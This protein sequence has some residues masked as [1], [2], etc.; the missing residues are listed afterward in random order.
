MWLLQPD[1]RQREREFR[2]RN[3][4]YYKQNKSKK[5]EK[6]SLRCKPLLGVRQMVFHGE[7]PSL[8]FCFFFT[9]GQKLHEIMLFIYLLSLQLKTPLN[10]IWQ[11]SNSVYSSPTI[12]STGG[13]N[14]FFI[15][16]VQNFYKGCWQF[17]SA[18]APKTLQRQTHWAGVAGARP[19]PLSPPGRWCCGDCNDIICVLGGKSCPTHLQ[20]GGGEGETKVSVWDV[21]QRLCPSSAQPHYSPWCKTKPVWAHSTWRW[22]LH[23]C[24]QWHQIPTTGSQTGGGWKG[25]LG[26]IWSKSGYLNQWK[27]YFVLFH[28]LQTV[29]GMLRPPHLAVFIRFLGYKIY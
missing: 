5:K 19:A 11:C 28:S 17:H 26:V 12:S 22:W 18:S 23:P 10:Q 25:L 27:Y 15:F 13:F 2:V 8:V 14:S 21:L 16:A 9:I 20:P 6:R 1:R 29:R 4:S 7:E 24:Y 3:N